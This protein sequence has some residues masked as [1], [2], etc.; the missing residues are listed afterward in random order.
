MGML[1]AL[2]IYQQADL[3]VDKLDASLRATADFKRYAKLRSYIA[4]QRRILQRMNNAID[5]RKRQIDLTQQ[6]L[7]LL[8]QRYEDGVQKFE[9]VDKDNLQEVERFRKY[10]EQLHVRLAQERREF[11]E[12]VGALEKEDAL[13]S[14][15]RI[16]LSRA[17][18]EYEE[19]KGKIEA[20][21]QEQK[22]EREALVKKADELA[23]A[24][25]PLLLERYKQAKRSHSAPLAWVDQNRCCGCNMEL[26]AVILRKL[27]EDAEVTE[28][29]NC[30]RILV[31]Q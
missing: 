12:L 30:G 26:P 31:M 1:S 20:Q 2:W 18:K 23:G 29:E 28:C 27:K 7:D 3:E 22:D 5:E 9:I 21:Q 17:N 15:M 14:D 8:M 25:E 11:S 4:E 10:F 16:K 6:R 19:L 13:L 24:V